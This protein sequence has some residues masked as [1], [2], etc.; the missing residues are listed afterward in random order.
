M[1]RLGPMI[2][3][4]GRLMT[5]RRRDP[6]SGPSEVMVT[7]EPLSSSGFALPLRA[8]SASRTDFGS[9]TARHSALR[10]ADHRHHQPGIGLRG[11]AQDAPR[12]SA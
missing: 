4:S 2:A 7:V 1:M 8:A 3:T 10:V 11:H 9:P 12:R 6:P 5:G